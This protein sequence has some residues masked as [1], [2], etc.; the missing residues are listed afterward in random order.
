MSGRKRVRRTHES[1]NAAVERRRGPSLA[2]LVAALSLLY[3]AMVAWV[4][5]RRDGYPYELE[6]LEGIALEHVQRLRHGLP[7][8]TAPS[9]AW[10]PLNYTPLYFWLSAA[11]ASVFGETFLAMRLVSVLSAV[12]AAA[13][14]W[15]LV[16]TEAGRSSP[17]WLAVGLFAATYRLGGAW[18]DVA[19]AD[20]LH[21]ALLLAA[22]WVARTDPTRWRMPLL[23]GTLLALAFM[24]K[25]TAVL[26]AGPL[27]AFL[28]ITDR[29]RGLVLAAVFAALSA[30][31]LFLLVRSSGGWFGY[32]AWTVPAFHPRSGALLWTFPVKDLLRWFAP[33]LA[34]IA[35]AARAS[36][37][38]V[39]RMRWGFQLALAAGF[40][41]L[42][43]SLRLYPGGYD[44]VLVPAHAALALLGA[45]AFAALTARGGWPSAVAAALFVVQLAL[46][47]WIPQA[48]V[49]GPGDRAAGDQ[50]VE[51]LRG[52]TGRVFFSSHT[53]LLA[54]AGRPTHA[55]VMPLMD[56]I[57]DGKGPREKA[58]LATLRDSL[59]AHVWDQAVLDNRDWLYEEFTRAGYRPVA[60]VFPSTDLFWPVTG[61]RTRPDYLFVSPTFAPVRRDAKP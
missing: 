52:L 34:A 6:W 50:V 17:A 11:T 20:S 51:G 49:P 58:L 55:H 4:W 28:V 44:N 3:V 21:L 59:G 40:I 5:V 7:L 27:V 14:M 9:L 31:G 19:R 39:A 57:R 22:A 36:R 10:V 42:G 43:W 8:Y 23:A 47:A 24:T 48:Q 61:M 12:A 29:P 25:Q 56:V 32:Y 30:A 54:R 16:R 1:S 46:V 60:A 53:Y 33:L 41:G 37:A 15:K 2:A 45:L 26:A 38:Q 18:F 35:L 13:L